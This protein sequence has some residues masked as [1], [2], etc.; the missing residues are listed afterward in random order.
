MARPLAIGALLAVGLVPAA[1]GA[2]RTPT[3]NV[4]S[5]L[6]VLH[7]H[8]EDRDRRPVTALTA[9]DFRVVEAGRPQAIAFFE[10]EDAPATIGLVI[11]SSGSMR[12][13]RSAVLAA[14]GAFAARSHPQDELFA[15]TFN[16]LVQ[17][18]L[19]ANGFTSDRQVLQQALVRAMITTG[20]TAL[21]DALLA[22]VDYGGRGRHARHVLV[23]VA[24]G[25]DNAS[26]ATLAQ[27]RRRLETADTI[28]Y[29]I[30]L[31]DPLDPERDPGRLRGLA[32]LTGGV[33]F[34]PKGDAGIDDAFTQIA[35]E[36]RSTYTLGYVPATVAAA[37]EFRE[38]RVEVR[39]PGARGWRVRTRLGYRVAPED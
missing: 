39:R 6:V 14:A 26:T 34:E 37:G 8:V 17:P 30:V 32:R 22:G 28:L 12:P 38:V 5:E 23:V 29:A 36:I 27:T 3:F 25:G 19:A 4:R 18:A 15:L 21:H 7:V 9:S 1:I 35:A 13:Q 33:A 11:D 16:D 10:A 31:A 24:D 20:R 2:Q